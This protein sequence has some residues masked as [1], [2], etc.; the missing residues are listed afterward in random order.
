MAE[1]LNV[2][3]KK[4]KRLEFKKAFSG[5]K[6]KP[7]LVATFLAILEMIRSS[8]LIAEYDEKSKDYILMKSKK[9]VTDE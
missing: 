5:R 2:L 3:L 8:K 4:N 9:E 6:S 7:E 1:K